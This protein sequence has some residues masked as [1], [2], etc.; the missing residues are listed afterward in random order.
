M[1]PLLLSLFVTA[2]E[3]ATAM[4]FGKKNWQKNRRRCRSERSEMLNKSN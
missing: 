2:E 4:L 3:M 1:A